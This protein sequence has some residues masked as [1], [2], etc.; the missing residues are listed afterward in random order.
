[1]TYWIRLCLRKKQRGNAQVFTIEHVYVG[2]FNL[3]LA[4]ATWAKVSFE[5][6]FNIFVKIILHVSTSAFAQ[7]VSKSRKIWKLF[8]TKA[9]SRCVS[10]SC[11]IRDESCSQGI[12]NYNS[13]TRKC[14]GFFCYVPQIPKTKAILPN[15]TVH[16][17]LGQLLQ[18][19]GASTV[20]C[21]WVIQGQQP[22]GHSS[23][24]TPYVFQPTNTYSGRN[25]S[26]FSLSSSD[27]K[28]VRLQWYAKITEVLLEPQ[29]KNR[30][31]MMLIEV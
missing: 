28:L 12:S 18:V 31:Y 3:F 22:C 19:C 21:G 27:T 23:S 20:T 5:G 4:A 10:S 1:M 29:W 16:Y 25:V 7:S 6:H 24:S 26:R 17:F 11:V 2:I 13:R 14:E 8:K 30:E 15:C 9:Q